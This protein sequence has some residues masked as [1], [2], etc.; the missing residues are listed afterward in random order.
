M[1]RY[2]ELGSWVVAIMLAGAF[3][4]TGGM[5]LVGSPDMLAS[6]AK[7]GYDSWFM[8]VIGAIEV[9]SAAALLLP[10]LSFFGALGIIAIML[11]ALFTHATHGEY[12]MLIVPFALAAMAG[13]LAWARRPAWLGGP[14]AHR[15]AE[16]ASAM[17]GEH[18]RHDHR[19]RH[20]HR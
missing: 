7:W 14:L 6:F 3:L 2:R 5:K 13:W 16:F 10:A 9:A 15:H 12:A 1:E 20:D 18:E 11:G 19:H 8:Y 17:P 4:L